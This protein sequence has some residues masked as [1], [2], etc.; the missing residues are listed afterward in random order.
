M[1]RTKGMAAVVL[2]AAVVA[3]AA[4]AALPSRGSYPGRTA[5]PSAPAGQA[6]AAPTWE[7]RDAGWEPS[8]R[9]ASEST[10]EIR[11]SPSAGLDWGDAGIGAAAI[12][13]LLSTA[14]G[15]TWR[16]AGRRRRRD[17]EVAAH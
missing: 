12:V 2:A 11:E 16:A 10:V 8:Q 4:A 1:G 5:A 3:S 15:L 9:R 6:Y 14:G 17:V 7:A 13:A